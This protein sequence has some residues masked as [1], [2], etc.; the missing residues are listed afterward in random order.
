MHAI[1]LAVAIGIHL[2]IVLHVRAQG[3]L[4]RAGNITNSVRNDG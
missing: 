1:G 4:S 2:A 3:A